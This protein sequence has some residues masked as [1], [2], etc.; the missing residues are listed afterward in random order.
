MAGVLPANVSFFMSR[1]QGVSVSHFK[2]FPQ[3]NVSADANK[4]IRFDLPSNSLVN[5]RSLRMLF[6]A[7]MTSNGGRLPN[8]IDSLVSRISIFCGGVLVANNFDNYHVF[9]HCKDALMGDKCD[10]ATG[11]PEIV[12]QKSYHNGLGNNN[13]VLATDGP[14]TYLGSAAKGI[15][16]DQ[17]VIDYWESFLGS[18]EPGIID[19]GLFPQITVEI[20]LAENNVCPTCA[21]VALSTTGA[22]NFCAVNAAAP[23]YSLTG[24]NM[25]V[26]VLGMATSVLDQIVE[27][28]I[29]SVGYL[30]LP[31]K[32]YFSFQNLHTGT[33]KFNI[34]SASWDR[35][36]I[37]YRA[38]T[39][40]NNGAPHPVAGYKLA[41]A[42]TS[43]TT[44]TPIATATETDVG[45][46]TYD[47][48][49]VL[50]T[51]KEK[52]VAPYFRFQHLPEGA[53]AAAKLLAE[54][55]FALQVNGASVPS[56]KMTPSEFYAVTKNSLDTYAT[57]HHMSM[58]Q[59][60]DSY[61]TQV[62]RFSLPDS[63]FGRLASGLDTRSVSA[64]VTLETKNLLAAGVTVNIFCEC[65][66]E[67]RVGSGRAIEVIQ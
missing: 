62:M 14:E 29:A 63:D 64:N 35:L 56:F 22:N 57:N 34:N 54:T 13:A 24:I 31:F 44:N 66:S 51:N 27:Q 9:R 28:R 52:Y 21:S 45:K 53:N 2:I 55:D 23:V 36:W 40:A 26:E 3:T 50:D 19:T 42:F 37:T 41:G 39:Y 46:P 48:G 20:T 33:T 15:G 6:S 5:L 8:K 49:G 65:T 32:N 58:N 67:L 4:I 1:L 25:Q 43:T 10:A 18:L 59:Y 12:R 38:T 11:H 7:G 30:S 16:R 61:F 17:F 47:V 60:L